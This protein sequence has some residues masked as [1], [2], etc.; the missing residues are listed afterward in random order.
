MMPWLYIG[1]CDWVMDVK[2]LDFFFIWT[3]DVHDGNIV[4]ESGECVFV[5]S[6]QWKNY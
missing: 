4:G 2:K 1:L 6:L 5:L 3:N